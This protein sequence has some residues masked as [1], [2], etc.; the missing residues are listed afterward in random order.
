MPLGQKQRTPQVAFTAALPASR[1]G[2]L[3]WV[4][5]GLRRSALALPEV[6]QKLKGTD[7]TDV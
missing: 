3:A 4:A 6:M 2:R 1:R 7:L 5:G